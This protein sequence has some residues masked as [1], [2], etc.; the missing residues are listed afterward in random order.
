MSCFRCSL[1]WLACVTASRQEIPI[2]SPIQPSLG[3]HHSAVGFQN[4]VTNAS[5]SKSHF[6]FP[7]RYCTEMHGYQVPLFSANPLTKHS[8]QFNQDNSAR[9]M[10][11]A[12]WVFLGKG[13]RGN[14]V[15]L[16]KKYYHQPSQ[17]WTER[18]CA[19]HLWACGPNPTWSETLRVI[20]LCSTTCLQM[21]CLKI[22]PEALWDRAVCVSALVASVYKW[23]PYTNGLLHLFFTRSSGMG[24][25]SATSLSKPRILYLRYSQFC[26]V[27]TIFILATM[28]TS[29]LGISAKI[30]LW[31]Y[32]VIFLEDVYHQRMSRRWEPLFSTVR[33]MW[34]SRM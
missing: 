6:L 2:P 17:V 3:T 25:C 13:Q 20:S 9:W 7:S 12:S 4:G 14:G 22:R 31:V 34:K 33:K 24:T 5:T 23:P 27:Y 21:E 18:C 16:N 26:F 29:G 30:S 11:P 8:F 15:F 1:L 10:A 32:V 19:E 28:S